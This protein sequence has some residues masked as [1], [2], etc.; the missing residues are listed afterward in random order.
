MKTVKMIYDLQMSHFEIVFIW[1]ESW[2]KMCHI[3]HKQS[4]FN[5]DIKKIV[6]PM[7]S[8]STY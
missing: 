2:N 1:I 7:S 4:N 6:F 3:F 8:K 5:I